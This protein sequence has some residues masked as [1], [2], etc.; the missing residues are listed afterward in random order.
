MPFVGQCQGR[1]G[2]VGQPLRPARPW[3]LQPHCWE[4]EGSCP[5]PAALLPGRGQQSLGEG[6]AAPGSPLPVMC[7]TKGLDRKA[8]PPQVVSHCRYRASRSRGVGTR[9]PRRSSHT[10]SCPSGCR[11]ALCCRDAGA[12][13]AQPPLPLGQTSGHFPRDRAGGP[14]QGWRRVGLY[15]A[16]CDVQAGDGH[17]AGHPHG[18]LPVDQERVWLVDEWL[19][20][21]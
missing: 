11:A 14:D 16:Q 9:M 15:R 17:A 6:P 18:V 19:L 7:T 13:R 10:T 21:V 8:W 2:A 20:P 3:C 1:T 4:L 5:L 12:V